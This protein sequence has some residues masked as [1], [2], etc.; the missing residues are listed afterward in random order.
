[1]KKIILF[2]AVAAAVLS[3]CARNEV[4]TP[5][6]DGEAVSFGA[7]SGRVQTKAGVT[8]DINLDALKT[9]GFGVFATFSG[10]EEFSTANDNF[11]Y[12]QQVAYGASAWEY[13]PVRYWPNPTSGDP[14]YVSFFAYA[15]YCEPGSSE[16]SGITRFSIDETTGHNMV[17]YAFANNEPNVDL[18]WGYQTGA[19]LKDADK[20]SDINANL[21]REDGTIHF[22]FRHVL[23]K[24]GG[25]QEA[26]T[27]PDDPAYTPNGLIIVA[28]PTA[29]PTESYIEGTPG[30]F[31][32]DTGTKITV[33]KIIVK[34]APADGT[35]T[36]INGDIVSY[37][38]GIQRATLD[39]YTGKFSLTTT[40][41]IEF[42]QVISADAAEVAAG[43]SELADWL[44]EVP[45]V[46]AFAD[47]NKGVTKKPVNVYKD[48]FNPIILLPGTAPVVDV[49]IT[50]TVRTYDPKLP[51]KEFTEVPQTVTGRVLFPTIDENKKY[52]LKIILGLADVNFEATV[53]DWTDGNDPDDDDDDTT[54]TTTPVDIT[55]DLPANN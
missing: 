24:L 22:T 34:S 21:T 39:L 17:H 20:D 10:T 40:N 16:T 51:D 4:Q 44:K 31:G 38:T 55:V 30:D 42:E 7:Y 50:Y 41:P 18:M 54:P 19:N 33:S 26:V 45:G 35:L 15:P 36:D 8:D 12:N 52:N 13:S 9:Y 37:S 2:A 1:M 23:A 6:M 14:Q 53:Q 43:A 28:N 27:D 5:V 3:G 46:T 48:E 29:D 11:M 47:V 49:T 32:T 25:S